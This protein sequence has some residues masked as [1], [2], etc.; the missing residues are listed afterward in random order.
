VSDPERV[1]A[2]ALGLADAQERTT[3][4]RPT[5]RVGDRIF[6]ALHDDLLILRGERETQAARLSHDSR[7]TP[8][9][10]WGRDGWVAIPFETIADG[11]LPAL[12]ADAHA[13]ACGTGR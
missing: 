1:R 4:G 11:E 7:L 2:L 5:F 12:L 13:L 9:P 8:A 10:H 3:W 6:A